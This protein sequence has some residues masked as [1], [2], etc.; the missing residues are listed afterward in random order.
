[1]K[2][3]E[4]LMYVQWVDSGLSLANNVW[5]TPEECSDIVK[6]TQPTET[7]GYKVYEDKDWLLLAQTINDGQ[8]RGAYAIYKKNI[9]MQRVLFLLIKPKKESK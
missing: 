6:E 7:V 2:H 1:M 8:I 4:D 9:I 5:Q 3:D